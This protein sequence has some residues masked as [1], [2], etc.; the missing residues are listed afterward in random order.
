L[1]RLAAG[2]LLT[3]CATGCRSLSTG[4]EGPELEPLPVEAVEEPI[5]V[6]AWA[7]PPSL[8]EG[9][10]QA[11]L[12]VR[13]QKKGGAAFAGVQVRL[14]T[15]TGTLFSAGR[16]LVT[17]GRGMTRDRLTTRRSARVVLNAGGTRYR[18]DVRVG[19]SVEATPPVRRLS[20][21]TRPAAP[22]GGPVR[23]R[24]LAP[25]PAGTH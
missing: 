24:E 7:E 15:S 2:A 20:H 21:M 14:V 5:V 10:G 13:V 1:R 8:P 3:L 4:D 12:L 18:F 16:I 19:D 6:A 9:G 25:A 17:D 23:V 11:Q 22:I